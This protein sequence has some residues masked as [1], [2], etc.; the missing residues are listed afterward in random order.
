MN[1]H[2]EVV[3]LL[4]EKGADVNIV[5]NVSHASMQAV[6]TV[7]LKYP[8]ITLHGFPSTPGCDKSHSVL[9][10]QEGMTAFFECKDK[11]I[12]RIMEQAREVRIRSPSN[13]TYRCWQ[14]FSQ[15]SHPNPI[16]TLQS[17]C[18]SI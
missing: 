10:Y 6:V 16:T 14:L 3:S 4:L 15:N 7:S 5:N 8:S 2:E 12:L 18:L 9:S 13:R 17:H 1:G 11:S